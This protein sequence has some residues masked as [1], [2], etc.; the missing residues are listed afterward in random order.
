[1]EEE[2]EEEEE[3]EVEVEERILLAGRLRHRKPKVV[4]RG[5]GSG[6]WMISTRTSVARQDAC[7][8]CGAISTSSSMW[9]STKTRWVVEGGPGCFRA[10]GDTGGGEERRSVFRV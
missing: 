5:G 4:G 3:E 6:G 1:M 8:C 9:L 10:G 7:R 2:E